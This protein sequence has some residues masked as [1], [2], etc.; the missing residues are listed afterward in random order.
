MLDELLDETDNLGD[1][2]VESGEEL[3][4]IREGY[5]PR[6]LRRLRRGHYS[7]HGHLDLHHMTRET[8]KTALLQF[9]NDAIIERLG[10]VR[11]V[12]GKGLRSPNKPVLK[13]MT[14]QLLR[15]HKGVVAFTS[16]RQIDGGT[17]A[18]VILLRQP[19]PTSG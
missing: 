11:V 8:A 5:A 18:V 6:L 1:L 14:N 15:R 4:F 9:L 2:D 3:R 10:C 19:G 7:V 16:C 17:G 13:Q 12:H